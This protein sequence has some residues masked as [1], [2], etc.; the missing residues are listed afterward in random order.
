[1][2][3]TLENILGYRLVAR[4]GEMGKVHDFLADDR[5][6][7]LKHLVVETG[8]WLDRRH[9]L[10]SPCS[11][12]SIDGE[13]REFVVNLSRD[14]VRQSP[15]VDTDRP[16]SQQ[17]ESR[18]QFPPSSDGDPHLRSFR[19]I[20]S[21]DVDYRG[22]VAKVQDFVIE[23]TDWTFRFI[24]AAIGGWFES[25]RVAIPVE[26]LT[27]ISYSQRKLGVG[28]QRSDLEALPL[29][30]PHHPVNIVEEQIYFDYYGRPT[31]ANA[32]EDPNGSR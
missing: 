10:I 2:L 22:A 31:S 30:D 11:L 17:E 24:V 1:M 9:V 20:S 13:R 28:L 5:C 16:V 14:E 15:G 27:G 21:Y 3:R 23:D 8:S 25:H 29:F 4:D 6:W 32:Q 18:T 26:A 19:E 12:G 7:R